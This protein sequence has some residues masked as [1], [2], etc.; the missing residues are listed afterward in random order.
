MSV[1]DIT[2]V[3]ALRRRDNEGPFNHHAELVGN[4]VLRRVMDAVQISHRGELPSKF[5]GNATPQQLLEDAASWLV[6]FGLADDKGVLLRH[7]TDATTEVLRE[8]SPRDCR[9]R[10]RRQ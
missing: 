5:P 3:E 7:L 10:G 4:I 1:D 2:A 6:S 9:G 8:Q